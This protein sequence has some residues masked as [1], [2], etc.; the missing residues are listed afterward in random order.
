MGRKRAYEIYHFKRKQILFLIF[1]I[2][3]LTFYFFTFL[4][5]LQSITEILF[6]L[7]KTCAVKGLT[8]QSNLHLI[9][10]IIKGVEDD[11]KAALNNLDQSKVFDSL[12]Q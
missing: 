9:P 10:T 4:R 8:I 5:S 6:G 1:L 3:Y 11:D 2:F 7:E 12:G